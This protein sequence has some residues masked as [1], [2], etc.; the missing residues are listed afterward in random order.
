METDGSMRT[1]RLCNS[2]RL[3]G[4]RISTTA[5]PVPLKLGSIPKTDPLNGAELP[6]KR[7]ERFDSVDFPMSLSAHNCLVPF[8]GIIHAPCLFKGVPYHVAHGENG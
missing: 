3:S 4:P 1:V 8:L 5:R 2:V 6:G 7:F